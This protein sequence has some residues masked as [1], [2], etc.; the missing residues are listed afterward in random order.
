MPIFIIEAVGTLDG[1]DNADI[2]RAKGISS[3]SR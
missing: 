2:A 3:P 1:Y